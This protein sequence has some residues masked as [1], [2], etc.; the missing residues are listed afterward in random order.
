MK[1]AVPD[2]WVKRALLSD[3]YLTA[4]FFFQVDQ[5]PPG[6]PRRRTRT[7]I[8]QQIQVAVRACVTPRKGTEHTHTL[9]AVLGRD[10]ENRGAFVLAQL[11]K[12]HAF[13]FSHPRQY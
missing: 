8:D 4:Q 11:I 3:V 6:E 10:G 5:Q 13:P 12:R 1:H 9:N 2:Q 7:G